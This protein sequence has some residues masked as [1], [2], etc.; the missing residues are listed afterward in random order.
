MRDD[1][2]GTEGEAGGGPRRITGSAVLAIGPVAP[3]FVG[4]TLQAGGPLELDPFLSLTDF[5]MSRPVFAPHPHAGFSAVT[6]MFTDSDG[7]FVNRDSLGDRSLIGPGAL[8]WTQAG[9]GMMHEEVPEVDGVDCHGLQLFVDL[10]PDHKD[11]PP[12]AFHLDAVDV[13][14]VSPSAGVTV[15]VV[16]GALGDT[17]SPLEGLLTPVT[18]LDVHLDAGA[19]VMLPVAS[20]HR[21]LLLTQDPVAVGEESLAAHSVAVL[22]GPGTTVGLRAPDG[23]SS[24]LW[25]SGR[26]IGA[27]VVVGGS[28]VMNTTDE[29][30]A[31]QERFHA[32]EMGTLAPSF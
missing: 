7:G 17:R 5:R 9:R 30:R 10:A 2:D 20:D 25:L 24:L 15:R 14:T 29:I 13:P 23:P 19:A 21:V 8:H 32:G 27:P 11:A 31:A 16:T 12:R 1:G 22:D 18:L 4:G 6:Y 28:F 26:P 3:G